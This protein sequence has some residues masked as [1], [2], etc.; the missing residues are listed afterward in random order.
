MLL[1]ADRGFYSYDLWN[2]ARDTGAD[3]LFRVGAN[4]VLP[5]IEAFPDG[6]YRSVLLPPKRQS[7]I[8]KL[9]RRR[10][11]GPHGD[12]SVLEAGGTACRV[13]EYSIELPD[14]DGA[15]PPTETIRLVTSLADHTTS[16]AAELA[17]LYHQ[18]WE[19]E[20][21]LKEIE[22]HQMG[23]SRVLRSKTPAMVRQEIW[24]MLLTHYAIR[25]L[26][27]EAA[28]SEDVDPDRLSFVRSL[29]LI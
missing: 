14:P 15:N 7:P 18:R 11:D 1:L 10:G 28:D 4:M 26:M 23:Q 17:A 20:L 2:A 27:H 22:M 29:R 19:F 12:L 3:L 6:S 9:A 21:S 8:R 13:I 25:H 24:G 5:V 16:P